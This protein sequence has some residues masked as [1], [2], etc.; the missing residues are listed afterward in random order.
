MRQPSQSSEK[1]ARAE[2]LRCIQEH[3]FA[4]HDLGLYLDTHP[5]DTRALADF[6]AHAEAYKTLSE[7]FADRFGALCRTQVRDKHGWAA[8]SNTPWPWEKEAN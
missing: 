6:Q 1:M 2:L 8:W 3:S 5:T 7:V 4:M